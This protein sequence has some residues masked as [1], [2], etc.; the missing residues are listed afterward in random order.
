MSKQSLFMFIILEFYP[1]LS[2]VNSLTAKLSCFSVFPLV[3][4]SGITIVF[5]LNEM[6]SAG[7]NEADGLPTYSSTL[8][9]VTAFWFGEPSCD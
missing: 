7:A 2:Q 1:F 9:M 5:T 3:L 8:H 6:A 4:S